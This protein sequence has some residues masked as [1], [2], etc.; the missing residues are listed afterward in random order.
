MLGMESGAPQLRDCLF[1]GAFQHKGWFFGAYFDPPRVGRARCNSDE[2]QLRAPW[3]G[4]KDNSVCR[5]KA[6]RINLAKQIYAPNVLNAEA[7][8]AAVEEGLVSIT[9]RRPGL[10]LVLGPLTCPS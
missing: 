4:D 5:P 3:P 1:F 9:C 7:V 10:R 6:T 2:T 8:E